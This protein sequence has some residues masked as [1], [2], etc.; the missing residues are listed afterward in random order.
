[1]LDPK[2]LLPGQIYALPGF[3]I[4][5][6]FRNIVSAANPDAFAFDVGCEKGRC[7]ALRWRWIPTE[8]DTGTHELNLS[9]W[10][11]EGLVAE[12]KTQIIVSPRNAGFGKKLNL[13]MIGDSC[14]V[15]KGHMEAL[16]ERFQLPDNPEMRMLGSQ[17]PGYGP[18][19]VGGPACEAYGGWT[20]S[21]YFEKTCSSNLNNDGLHPARPHDVRS[22]FL[23]R[24]GDRDVF[25]FEA[26]LEKVSGGNRPDVI[27]FELGINGVFGCRTDEEVNRKW[28]V[29][30]FPNMTR[31]FQEIRSVV[32]KV[33]LA[34]ELFQQG[35]WSQDAF[36]CNYG[37]MQTRRRWMLNTDLIFRKYLQYADECGYQVIPAY[38]N[39]DGEVNYPGAEEPVYSSSDRKIFRLNNAVHPHPEGFGQWAD[40]EYFFLKYLLDRGFCGR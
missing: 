15:V 32:P 23:F 19:A 17:A 28:E 38:I 3:E 27:C 25:D 29:S 5:I 40:S 33:Q 22:P 8:A 31:M 35:A 30:I 13:L 18:P 12:A 37:C 11:N 26:Y 9:V 10:S 16:H 39:M 1:M 14:T 7:D 36:G 2:L 34:V 6:Y 24:K 21:T 4:N 20:W